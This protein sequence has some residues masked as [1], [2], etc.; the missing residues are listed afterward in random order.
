MLVV[1]GRIV[2]R[3]AVP[4]RGPLAS[5]RVRKLAAVIDR[6]LEQSDNCRTR[7]GASCSIWMGI[8]AGCAWQMTAMSGTRGF[9]GSRDARPAGAGPQPDAGSPV[10]GQA[11]HGPCSDL[12]GLVYVRFGDWSTAGECF[13]GEA[14]CRPRRQAAASRRA[15]CQVIVC[16]LM[17]GDR[18]G[19][20]ET[21]DMLPEQIAH[22]PSRRFRDKAVDKARARLL[23]RTDARQRLLDLFQDEQ[24]ALLIR[25]AA[26]SGARRGELAALYTT[27]LQGRVL[28]ICRA[29]QDG[30]IGPVKNHLNGRLTLAAKHRHLLGP[31]RSALGSATGRQG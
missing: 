2:R 18:D 14:L 3:R 23:E 11:D 8:W 16:E 29:S 13:S 1:V 15:W 17:A 30:I 25:L 9:V 21:L 10:E 28:S 26:D 20:R 19:A 7:S 5:A 27:D 4:D 24:N 31:A 22:R 6:C 12:L